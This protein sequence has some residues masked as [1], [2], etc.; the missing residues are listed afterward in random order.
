MINAGPEITTEATSREGGLLDADPGS[1]CVAIHRHP[2]PAARAVV[3]GASAQLL[4]YTVRR[5]FH[6]VSAD[7]L[8]VVLQWVDRER[9]FDAVERLF[10]FAQVS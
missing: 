10:R 1:R 6:Q 4:G 9:S 5:A 8:C 3:A 7:L 2:G